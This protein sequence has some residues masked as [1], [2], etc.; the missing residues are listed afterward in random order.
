MLSRLNL[1]AV[2]VG[3]MTGLGG[4][5][6]LALPLFAVG[7]A[8]ANTFGGQAALILVGF[9]GQVGAGFVATRFAGRDPGLHGGLAGLILFLA[10]AALS[11]A[12]G[13]DPPIPTLAFGGVVALLLGSAGGVLAEARRRGTESEGGDYRSPR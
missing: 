7:I 11:I 8:D 10:V 1:G 4:G 9:V 2:V 3:G 5:V 12:A 6:I 13:S